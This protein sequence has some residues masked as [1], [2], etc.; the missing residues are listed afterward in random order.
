MVHTR[1][2]LA[3]IAVGV[4]AIALAVGSGVYFTHPSGIV[5]RFGAGQPWQIHR[6]GA[7]GSDVTVLHGV[8]PLASDHVRLPPGRYSVR[9]PEPGLPRCF[10][11][12]LYRVRPHRWSTE[13]F[14][15][16]SPSCPP[17]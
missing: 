13:S 4:F 15:F 16:V 11:G 1:H 10:T 7:D 17:E 6:E 12:P 14:G 3:P 9:V 2:W 8:G 5:V